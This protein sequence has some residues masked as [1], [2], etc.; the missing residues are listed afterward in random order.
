MWRRRWIGLAAAWLVGA[1]GAVLLSRIPDRYEAIA[2]IYVD[3]ETVLR[4]LIAGLAVQPNTDQQVAMLA[5]TLLTRPNIETL[6]RKADLDHDVRSP[7]D[8]RALTESLVRNIRLEASGRANLYSISYRDSN[9]DRAKRT[10]QALVSLFVESGLGDKRRDSE[11]ARHFIDDQIKSHETRLAEAETRLKDFKL[12][13]LSFAGVDG[14]DYFSRVSQLTEEL[15]KLRIELRVAEQT[16]DATKRQL[17][18]EEPI[19]LPDASAGP[20]VA[21]RAENE[22][23]L[24]GQKK[25]L[26]D[27]LRR[28]TEE[29][30]DVLAARRA[31]V[32]LEEERK[33][34]L[35]ARRRDS[36]RGTGMSVAN[37]PVF[38][39][40]KIALS[41]SEANVAAT[42]ARVNEAYGR[43]EQLRASASRVPQVEAELAQLNRDYEVIRRNY[44]QL[45]TR[46]EQAAMSED[47]DASARF[48]DFRVIEPPRVLPQP[49][50]PNRL[51][52]IPIVLLAALGAGALICFVLT[53]IFP[54]FDS[55]KTLRTVT[56][57]PVLGSITLIVGEATRQ[58]AVRHNLAF[59]VSLSVLVAAFGGWLAWV[60]LVSTRI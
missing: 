28:Y 37:N 18:G 42:Q 56:Q 52:L 22:S 39:R 36:G 9:Q 10:V 7:Q 27:L 16:R 6:V 47:A 30:P 2:R 21:A 41:E 33:Q 54:T 4:P 1:S 43:L 3:T 26:D 13:N 8:R 46:R 32:R 60:T 50:F 34:E 40:I 48:A 58:R 15:N 51:V 25:I 55:T 12:R 38:Q 14:K 49:V 59:G 20:A 11:A 53:Q 35:D 29:H 31:I 24:D 17:A 57:R 5:R 19:L 44:D 23:R 45:V